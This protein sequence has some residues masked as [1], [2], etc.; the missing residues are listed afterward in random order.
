MR[1]LGTPCPIVWT[2]GDRRVRQIQ[3]IL[4]FLLYAAWCHP[5]I[6]HLLITPIHFSSPYNLF[7][8]F[9]LIYHR[10][11][12]P[13]LILHS[14]YLCLPFSSISRFFCPFFPHFFFSFS[15]FVIISGKSFAF[16]EFSTHKSAKS[17]VEASVRRGV[18]L[19]GRTISIGEWRGL[20]GCR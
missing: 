13:L 17:V 6:S 10:P 5:A 11:S 8:F 12:W 15:F 4:S 1:S 7:L 19:K 18:T 3:S 14:L 20:L 9:S 16:V 2:Y